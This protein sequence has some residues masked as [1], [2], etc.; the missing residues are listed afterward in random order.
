[1]KKNPFST[2]LLA[3]AFTVVLYSCSKDDEF[4]YKDQSVTGNFTYVT[5]SFIPL[6]VDPVSQQPLSASITLQGTAT[7][8]DMGKI[9]MV[10]SFKFDFVTGMGSEFVTTYTGET[11]ADSYN[12]TGSSQRQQDGSITVTESFNNG[13]GK[14]S[15]IKGGGDTKVMLNPDG[16]GG[17][18]AATWKVT[19]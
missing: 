3:L 10:S 4:S 7:V 8:T 1:M 5:T 18:G 15:K 19:Y 9:N 17:T 13:K 11:A 12:A 2:L 14:F 6:A 16:S